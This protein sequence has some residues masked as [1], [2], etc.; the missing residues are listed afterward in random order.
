MARF[1]SGGW[2]VAFFCADSAS[3]Y[4]HPQI[5]FVPNASDT[6]LH[7]S[8]LCNIDKHTQTKRNIHRHGQAFKEN[9]GIYD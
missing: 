6:S 8:I 7:K 3:L 5:A 2:E 4:R 1:C 9:K